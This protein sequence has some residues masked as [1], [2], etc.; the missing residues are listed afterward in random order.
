[1]AVV[2][3]E[4]RLQA[5]RHLTAETTHDADDVNFV[6]SAGQRHEVGDNDCTGLRLELG[7]EDQRAIAVTS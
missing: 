5:H 7:V 6:L 1:M 3:P 4:N 2:E